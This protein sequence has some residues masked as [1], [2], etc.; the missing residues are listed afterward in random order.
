MAVEHARLSGMLFMRRLS[1]DSGL[2][3]GVARTRVRSF[4]ASRELSDLEAFRR[5]KIIGWRLSESNEDDLFQPEYGDCLN[6][7][8]ARF[9]GLVEAEGAG[10]RIRG[11]VTLSPLM[12]V[13]LSVF[14]LAAIV[15]TMIAFG[16]AR[17]ASAEVVS[18]AATIL[19]GALLMVRY[20]LRST[21]RVVEDGLRRCLEQPGRKVAA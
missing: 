21:C 4:G 20:S 1:I 6:I 17:D 16:K 9:V 7:D 19:G 5:R 18:I 13:V 3:V 14:M 8:G 11:Y 10:S 15:A 2:A 12:R